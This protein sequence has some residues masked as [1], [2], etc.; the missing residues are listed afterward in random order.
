MI[1]SILTSHT[2]LYKTKI[3]HENTLLRDNFI[4]YYGRNDMWLDTSLPRSYCSRH[5]RRPNIHERIRRSFG[6]ERLIA[7]TSIGANFLYFQIT[8][9][10]IYFYQ[11]TNLNFSNLKYKYV[12]I[13]YSSNMNKKLLFHM[14]IYVV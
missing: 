8:A 11:Y 10:H 3:T 14:L 6:Y 4:F 12:N 5:R 2:R 1:K 9:S 7:M 13:F